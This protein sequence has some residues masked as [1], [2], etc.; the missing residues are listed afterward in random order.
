MSELINEKYEN[1][2]MGIANEDIEIKNWVQNWKENRE[3]G[4]KLDYTIFDKKVDRKKCPDDISLETLEFEIGLESTFYTIYSKDDNGKLIKD[5]NDN[6]IIDEKSTKNLLWEKICHIILDLDEFG[7][8][9]DKQEKQ[10]YYPIIGETEKKYEIIEVK[11]ENDIKNEI[12]V[13]KP[14]GGKQTSSKSR[15]SKSRKSKKSR[16]SRKSR[17]SKKYGGTA[18]DQLNYTNNA[19]IPLN[20][21]RSQNMWWHTITKLNNLNMYGSSLPKFQFDGLGNPFSESNTWD[22]YKNFIYFLSVLNIRRIISLQGCGD[23]RIRNADGSDRAGVSNNTTCRNYHDPV[24]PYGNEWE[25]DFFINAKTHLEGLNPEFTGQAN[26]DAIQFRNITIND[27]A[28]GSSNAWA[29]LARIPDTNATNN[30]N[31]TL[32]HCYAGFGRT[33]AALLFYMIRDNNNY[34]QGF[35]NADGFLGLGTSANMYN[36][37]RD[38]LSQQLQYTT[39]GDPIQQQNIRRY[40]KQAGVNEV[41]DI[42]SVF[43]AILFV[44]RINN[45]LFCVGTVRGLQ[46]IPIYRIPTGPCTAA[47]IFQLARRVA[48]PNFANLNVNPWQIPA[49]RLRVEI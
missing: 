12:V 8:Y 24:G 26:L 18:F 17:K 11:I 48:A 5:D 32:V 19:V 2:E 25:D 37:L 29:R 31:G 14:V 20:F 1:I 41:F 35:N 44:A 36:T 7:F 42:T 13:N 22:A 45:I 39:Q 4:K 27:M 46:N 3:K 9:Y 34:H 28:V 10:I 21:R 30:P 6:L 49:N 16:K 33:G 15:K 40:N 43:N 23:D 38:V 47:D